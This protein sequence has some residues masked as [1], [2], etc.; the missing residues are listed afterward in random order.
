VVYTYNAL[1]R[2]T[3]IVFMM[4]KMCPQRLHGLVP[5]ESNVHTFQHNNVHPHM[6]SVPAVKTTVSSLW[7]E[8]SKQQRRQLAVKRL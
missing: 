4:Y 6:I 8:Q 1:K 5:K 2:I 7:L 3:I